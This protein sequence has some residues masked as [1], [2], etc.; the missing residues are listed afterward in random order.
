MER[1]SC[2][3]RW[4]YKEF[5]LAA[6][7]KAFQGGIATIDLS[8]G[9]CEPGHAEADLFVI[10]KFAETVDATA[11]E[12]LVNVNLGMEIEVEWWN[13]SPDNAIVAA[14]VGS[15]CYVEDDQT[16]GILATGMALAGRIWAVDSVRGVAVQKLP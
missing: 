10:G 1:M 5:P 3:E 13:N 11:G 7:A 14:N 16:V 6:G 12:K 15:L 8:T 2:F 4:T 9:K